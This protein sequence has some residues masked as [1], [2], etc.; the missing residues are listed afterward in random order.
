[1]V[2][3]VH[4]DGASDEGPSH[5]EVQFWWTCRHLK[6]GK[7]ATLVTT[8]SSGSSYSLVDLTQKGEPGK[9]SKKVDFGDIR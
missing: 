4:V 9:N 2:D 7:V 1:M 5:D 3:C 8:R 6:Q